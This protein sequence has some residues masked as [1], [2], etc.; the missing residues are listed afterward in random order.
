LPNTNLPTA[1]SFTGSNHIPEDSQRIL[2]HL[3]QDFDPTFPLLDLELL[4]TVAIDIRD[5]ISIPDFHCFTSNQTDNTVHYA[6]RLLVDDF[7]N[8]ALFSVATAAIS[9]GFFIISVFVADHMANDF[10]VALKH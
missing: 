10:D 9:L 4:L 7:E 5:A 3:R 2:A 1:S 8:G 6:V